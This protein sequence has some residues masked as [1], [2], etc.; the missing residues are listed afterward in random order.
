VDAKF[1]DLHVSGGNQCLRA[2]MTDDRNIAVV[3][4]RHAQ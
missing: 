1:E 2:A 4:I 3:C